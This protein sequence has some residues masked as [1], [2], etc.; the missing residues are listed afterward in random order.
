MKLNLFIVFSLI[1]LLKG[2]AQFFKPTA[3]EANIGYG[4]SAPYDDVDIFNTGFYAQAEYILE[5]S[6]WFDVR[7]YAGLILTSKQGRASN[8]NKS[9]YT[10][11]SKAFL[12]GGKGRVTFP[13]PWIAPYFELGIG[14]S[15][16]AF[17]TYTPYTNIDRTGLAYH[18]PFSLGLEL[19]REHNVDVAFT[20]YY[21]PEEEQ[22]SGALAVGVAIPL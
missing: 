16:G 1:T 8:G 2:Y 9:E 14:A 11:S 5:A 20:Y 13:I 19:G 12:F 3:I 10:S 22:F 7:P 4:L 17:R 18:I 15:I 6:K 21:H